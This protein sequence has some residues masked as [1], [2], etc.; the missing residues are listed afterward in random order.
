MRVR[1]PPRPP[2][3]NHTINV[4][5]FVTHMEEINRV[6]SSPSQAL[7]SPFFYLYT[8]HM[9]SLPELRTILRSLGLTPRQ[10]N[11]YLYGLKSGPAI[12]VQYATDLKVNRQQMYAELERLTEDGVME[13]SGIR[14]KR[15]FSVPP[16]QLLKRE[17]EKHA[18]QERTIQS[19]SA[20]L[21][22][23]RAFSAKMS[24]AVP[25][26]TAY[27][28]IERVRR[29]YER[30]LVESK[31]SEVCSI[32]GSLEDHFT[33]LSETYWDNW[34][35]RFAQQKSSCR[36][37]VHASEAALRVKAKDS[38]YKRETRILDQF[39]AT[40]NID[41]FGPHVLL[42]SAVEQTALWIESTSIASSYRVLFEVLWRVA[43]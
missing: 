41:I 34:N 10:V 39:D 38:L 19:L 21:P 23:L 22:A 31:G 30:E 36:M 43:T 33:L 13:A 27:E 25:L 6:S 3:K 8:P 37:L 16:E 20:A 26:M 11:I 32:V 15:Y 29:A 28:G 12:V 17:E 18:V 35:Q 14:P 2:C 4:W 7:A 1:V 5:F 9:S 24:D 40:I 42:A